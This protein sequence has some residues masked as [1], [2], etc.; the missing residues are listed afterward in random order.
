MISRSSSVNSQ[1]CSFSFPSNTV[2]TAQN[3]T[4]INTGTEDRF[5]A[6]NTRLTS[7]GSRSSYNT[8]GCKLPSPAWKTLAIRK[9]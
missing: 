5:P 8:S 4:E 2:L 1:A 6:C 3:T 7:S 9:P